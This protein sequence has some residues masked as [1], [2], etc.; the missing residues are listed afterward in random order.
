VSANQGPPGRENRAR[1]K[2]GSLMSAQTPPT[3]ADLTIQ[4]GRDIPAQAETSR[5]G[6]SWRGCP[7]GCAYWHERPCLVGRRLETVADYE[8]RSQFLG[9]DRLGCAH[10]C[11]VICRRAA[12]A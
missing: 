5:R 10:G 6:D 9:G 1:H 7:L 8:C 4:A 12:V 3:E 2:P 11:T